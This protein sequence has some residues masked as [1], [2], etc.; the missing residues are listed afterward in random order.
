MGNQWSLDSLVVPV[1]GDLIVG[2]P[3][4]QFPGRPVVQHGLAH[5]LALVLL[6]ADEHLIFEVTLVTLLLGVE[7]RHQVE[8]QILGV[9]CEG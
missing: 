1:D 9:R 7:I 4:R 5:I 6:I 3:I 8:T 2:C